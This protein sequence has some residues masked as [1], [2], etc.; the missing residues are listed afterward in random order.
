MPKCG[1]M[2]FRSYLLRKQGKCDDQ[3]KEREMTMQV[4][5]TNGLILTGTL[6]QVV[7]AAR[8]LGV[9]LGEDGTY[10]NSTSRGLIRIVDMDNNHLQNTL[11]KRYREWAESLR[12]LSGVNLLN[13]LNSGPSDA[14][15]KAM[16][17]ELATRIRRGVI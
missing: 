13:A 5:L 7:D 14:T 6:A 17:V 9:Q 10:Y 11:R 2:T 3:L 12:T 8:K 4:Q 1:D 16:A 15:T